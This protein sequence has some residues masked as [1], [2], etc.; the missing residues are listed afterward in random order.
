VDLSH[1]ML[2]RLGG[3][4]P[5]G[6]LNA[7]LTNE[8]PEE[9]HRGVRAERVFVGSR[10]YDILDLALESLDPPLALSGAVVGPPSFSFRW[11][12]QSKTYAHARARV[13]RAISD[14][15]PG[16]ERRVMRGA[17]TL[18]VTIRNQPQAAAGLF[19]RFFL[20]VLAS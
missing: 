12:K 19:L 15:T 13:S 4:D 3:K 5:V 11:L 17:S 14:E 8:V 6:M 7:V 1:K 10:G 16:S 20:V 18:L 2:L 9:K